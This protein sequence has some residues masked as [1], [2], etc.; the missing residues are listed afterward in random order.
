M[1]STN[2]IAQVFTSEAIKTNS[3]WPFMTLSSFEVFVSNTRAQASTELVVVAPFVAADQIEQWNDYSN[4][5]QGW[6]DES[7]EEYDAGRLDL[8]PIPSSVYRFGRF[9]GRTVLKPE[10]GLG[11]FPVAPFWQMSRPP[12]DTSIIN[13][14]SLS[15]EAYQEM[16]N[17]MISTRNWV[18]G[19][20]GP[21]VLIDYTISEEAHDELHS[22]T[23]VDKNSTG[24]ANNHPHTSLFY[25]IFRDKDASHPSGNDVNS[26]I[27]A[28]IINILPWDSYLKWLLPPGVNGIYCILRNSAGQFF[29]YQ[30]RGSDALYLGPGDLHETSYDNQEFLVNFTDFFEETY[31]IGEANAN[32]NGNPEGNGNLQYWLSIYPSDELENSYETNTPAIFTAVIA[33]V[34]VFMIVTF[35]LYD[36]HGT[37][38]HRL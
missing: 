28:M 33:G 29:S 31:S 22:A 32:A 4:N 16:Y 21:N 30:L 6:I 26:P 25:P 37:F 11:G 1:D 20:A 19:P 38:L 18:L 7:F 27:V 14:N 23:Q 34:F 17:A 8:N 10:D 12:Y 36:Y 24:F 15:E 35:L 2:G 9:K 5:N 13:F 3:E